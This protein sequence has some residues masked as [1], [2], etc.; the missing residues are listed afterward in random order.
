MNSLFLNCCFRSSS[1][2][3][4]CPFLLASFLYFFVTRS[5]SV[6]SLE[7]FPKTHLQLL[8]KRSGKNNIIWKPLDK[9]YSHISSC[10]YQALTF[11]LTHYLLL[12]LKKM[13][14]FMKENFQNLPPLAAIPETADN[15]HVQNERARSAMDYMTGGQP[16]KNTFYLRSSKHFVQR[17]PVLFLVGFMCNDHCN[18]ECVFAEGHASQWD[19]K[20][21]E[22]SWF[23]RPCFLDEYFIINSGITHGAQSSG[24]LRHKMRRDK[25]TSLCLL[26]L[27]IIWGDCMTK[28]EIERFRLVYKISG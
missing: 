2:F 4:N 11:C 23:T 16:L 15:L 6:E 25:P 20:V 26:F 21:S 18:N 1:S 10:V 12:K 19:R 17:F 8:A 13:F 14:L 22:T 24:I 3:S 9:N 27:L 28:E 7:I 5:F